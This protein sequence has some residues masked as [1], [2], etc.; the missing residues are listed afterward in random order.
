[1]LS[2]VRSPQRGRLA[3]S[4]QVAHLMCRSSSSWP[5]VVTGHTTV[6]APRRNKALNMVAWMGAYAH[7]ADLRVRMAARAC[8]CLYWHTA[9]RR[10]QPQLP[11]CS[12]HPGMASNCSH[13][14]R[15]R[16]RRWMR[17]TAAAG[18]CITM[19]CVAWRASSSSRCSDRQDS[20]AQLWQG[21]HDGSCMHPTRRRALLWDVA[22]PQ[23][24]PAAHRGKKVK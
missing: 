7:A 5:S 14:A 6:R 8:G 18:S 17:D 1:M 3:A 23:P 9:A 20:A 4:C 19:D 2:G 10:G 22:A 15:K 21:R 11:S 24:A 12:P 13:L 16:A